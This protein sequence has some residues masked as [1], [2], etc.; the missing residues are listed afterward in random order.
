M[1]YK[2]QVIDCDACVLVNMGVSGFCVFW[3][4]T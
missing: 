4:K 1:C 3:H 2:T